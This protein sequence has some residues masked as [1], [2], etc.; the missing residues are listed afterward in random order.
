MLAI[1]LMI[2]FGHNLLDPISPRAG[3][4]ADLAWSIFHERAR[5]TLWDGFVLRVS[6]PVLPYIGVIG[7]GYSL[8]RLYVGQ[9]D[10]RARRVTLVAGGAACILLFL[11]LRPLN[12]YGERGP[13]VPG[14]SALATLASL[15]NTTKYPPSL[16][17]LLMTL[18]PTLILLAAAERLKGRIS[19]AIALFGAA[20]M[21]FYILHLFVLHI[22]NFVIARATGTPGLYHFDR[23]EFVWAATVGFLA[24]V[25]PLTLLLA[26]TLKR[27]TAPR[28]PE[29]SHP[30]RATS[31]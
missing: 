31:R 5:F 6:Y 30:E 11:A 2:I 29:G 27:L 13:F 22:T 18:G 24:V 21:V 14:V 12:L 1:S 16:L 28:I 19:E 17:F 10:P 25:G 20:P 4:A 9:A 7:L 23:I 26:G 8:G 15:L 3:L